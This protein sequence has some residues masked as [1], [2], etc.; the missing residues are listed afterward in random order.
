VQR[1]CGCL[2]HHPNTSL[3]NTTIV[4]ITISG[5]ACQRVG[6]PDGLGR[7]SV[8]QGGLGPASTLR[9]HSAKAAITRF[10]CSSPL[11]N[12]DACSMPMTWYLSALGEGPIGLLPI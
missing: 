8:H 1:C 6:R 5:T 10:A 9:Q 2:Q 7:F 3:T 4:F 12:A 11:K